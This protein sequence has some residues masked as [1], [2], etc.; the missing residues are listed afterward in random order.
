[1]V[2]RG[3]FAGVICFTTPQHRLM[4]E[5]RDGPSVAESMHN[6]PIKPKSVM[7]VKP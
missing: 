5:P 3:H 7:P 2:Q 1:M 4:R 6:G